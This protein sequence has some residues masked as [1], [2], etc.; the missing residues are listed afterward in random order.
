[1]RDNQQYYLFESGNM[2]CVSAMGMGD[3]KAIFSRGTLEFECRSFSNNGGWICLYKNV[4][5]VI[6]T[7]KQLCIHGF[8]DF[9]TNYE[10]H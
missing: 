5:F 3:G 9:L 10:F 2:D 7:M 4:L 1:M 6:E 8:C